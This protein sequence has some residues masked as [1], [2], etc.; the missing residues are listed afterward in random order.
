MNEIID[1][2]TQ[3]N[4]ISQG[5]ITELDSEEPSLDWIQTEL[6]RREEYVNDI[7]VITS[8]NEIITLKVQE[9]ESLRL[10]FEKFV[11]LNRKI[12][13]TLKAKLEK[14]REKLETAATQ[15]KAVKG[16]KI[17]NSYKFS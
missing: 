6:R 7:Q 11:E 16:Y 14:Q 17:S 10:G 4:T 9:Q 15:R 3:L 13:A 12:Q 2:L 8:N 5:I 1:N